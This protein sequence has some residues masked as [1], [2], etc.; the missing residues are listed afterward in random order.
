[1]PLT[2]SRRRFLLKMIK[3]AMIPYEHPGE[4]WS[5][6][7]KEFLPLF[8]KILRPNSLILDLAGGYGRVTPHLVADGNRVVL[9]DLSTHSLRL[10]KMTLKG[11]VNLVRLDMLNLPF[12][13]NTF[14]GIW[15]TQ[16]FEYVPPDLRENFLRSIRRIMRKGGVFFI[17]VARVP[18][19][20]SIFSYLKNYL[21]WKM[22]KRQPVKLGDFIYKLS[23][24][25]YRGW[26]YHSVVFTKR[27]EKTFR[28][29]GFEI[30]KFRDYGRKGYLTYLLQAKK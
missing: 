22:I 11:N 3:E 24:E 5:L 1:M 15:F 21:Y 10:A 19:E 18:N 29:T 26:H 20:C 30:L 14:N 8:M 25:H 7:E 13:E 6:D 9:A 28:K 17:N 12:R 23:L 27:I 4:E 16:A 2:S